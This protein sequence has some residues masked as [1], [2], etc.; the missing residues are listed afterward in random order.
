[1]GCCS[2]C[3]F[4]TELLAA[5]PEPVAI[6]LCEMLIYFSS[7]SLF[8]HLCCLLLCQGVQALALGLEGAVEGGQ[9]CGSLADARCSPGTWHC[10]HGLAVPCWVREVQAALPDLGHPLGRCGWLF[11]D[12]SV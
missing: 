9:G 10:L 12:G 7:L 2:A 4:G 11:D 5:F 8:L 1:M 6:F 3:T